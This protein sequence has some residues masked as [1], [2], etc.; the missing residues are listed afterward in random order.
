MRIYMKLSEDG[1][2]DSGEDL[3][4]YAAFVRGE[5][6]G[7]YPEA[8]IDIE[9]TQRESGVMPLVIDADTW[10]EEEAAHLEI[11]ELWDRYCSR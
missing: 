3:E 11:A 1:M 2:G 4:S 10:Q 8:R 5:L 9:T 7:L 6:S